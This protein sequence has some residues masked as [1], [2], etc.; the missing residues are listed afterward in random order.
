[1]LLE[2]RN[3]TLPLSP[4][5]LSSVALIGP[6]AD[7]VTLGDYVFLNS[8]NNG[9]T[10][11]AGFQ[12]HLAA[13]NSSVQVNYAQGCALWSN[14]QSG[15]ADAVAAAQKSDVAVVMVGTWSLDQTN[16]WTPGTNATTGEHVDLSDL[17][18]VGA[19]G[20][21]VRA[22][23]ATGKPTVVVFVSGKPVAEPWIQASAHTPLSSLPCVRSMFFLQT[24][25][26][27]C[28]SST[29]ATSA[30]SRS[31]KCSSAQRSRAGSCRS[32]SLG[33]SA[34]RPRSTTTGRARARLTPAASSTTARSCSGTSTCSTAPSRSGASG[35]A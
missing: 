26:Q 3:G 14:D 5:A 18:L 22:I 21:L 31:R 11:L 23:K 32:R 8:S 10:P 27:L 2:N 13:V 20:A 35:T 29:R 4:T 15:F 34:P 1:V 17:A 28:S 19:Q 9:I 24:R 30:A 25:M 12:Q 16:L 7:R 33:A 6:Q